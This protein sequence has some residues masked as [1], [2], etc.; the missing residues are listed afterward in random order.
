MTNK[1]SPVLARQ[2]ENDSAGGSTALLVLVEAHAGV[3][4]EVIGDRGGEFGAFPFAHAGM[5]FL[6]ATVVG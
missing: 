4:R 5:P 1:E 2:R 6:S 3:R